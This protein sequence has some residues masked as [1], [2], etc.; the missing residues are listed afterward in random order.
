VVLWYLL[1]GL[2]ICAGGVMMWKDRSEFLGSIFLLFGLVLLF[3]AVHS[4][5]G[6]SRYGDSQL[7]LE[8]P[9][10]PGKEARGTVLVPKRIA[11]ARYLQLKV[12]CVLVEW[13]GNPGSRSLRHDPLWSDENRFPLTRR[14]LGSECAF[15]FDLPRNTPCSTIG[16]EAA[17]SGTGIYWEITAHADVPGIDYMR[18][19]RIPVLGV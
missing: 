10:T 11:D 16:H 19:F 18:T 3:G 4:I 6:R 14:G 17:I 8:I 12:R 2:A 5:L 13:A 15:A 7:R 1:F 9:L